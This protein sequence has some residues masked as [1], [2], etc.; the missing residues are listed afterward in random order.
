MT[1]LLLNHS[2]AGRAHFKLWTSEEAIL[3]LNNHLYLCSQLKEEKLNWDIITNRVCAMNVNH[4]IYVY[5]L[6]H[7]FR[8]HGVSL[9]SDW[10]ILCF[11]A[12][13]CRNIAETWVQTTS[14]GYKNLNVQITHTNFC[15]NLRQRWC[16]LSLIGHIARCWSVY[17]MVEFECG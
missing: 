12:G 3:S 15:A 13:F 1:V 2:L 8:V 5:P 9:E 14:W 6:L 10:Y 4:I 17:I 11:L 7:H 16:F